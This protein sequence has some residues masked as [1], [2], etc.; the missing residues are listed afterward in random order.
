[1]NA[2]IET[3]VNARVV[4][5]D[6]ARLTNKDLLVEWV[7]ATGSQ[8]G[9]N[10]L[11]QA[12]TLVDGVIRES[13]CF[14][15]A[16]L[17]KPEVSKP[18][19]PVDEAVNMTP[20]ELQMIKMQEMMFKLQEERMA[21]ERKTM[22]ERIEREAA[23]R[24]AMEERIE[25]EAMKERMEDKLHAEKMAMEDKL[26]A[27]KLIALKASAKAAL[28]KELKQMDL[29]DAEKDRE[30]AKELKDMDLADA[31]KHRAFLAREN[32]KNRAFHMVSRY[33][34][35]L[36]PEVFGSP[37]KQ[38]ITSESLLRMIDYNLWD[39][40]GERPVEEVKK[41]YKSIESKSSVEPLVLGG[42][43]MDNTK[44]IAVD[45]ALKV[46]EHVNASIAP[47]SQDMLIKRLKEI[48]EIAVR[49]EN[50]H[51]PVEMEWMSKNQDPDCKSLTKYKYV[52]MTNRVES[53]PD[54]LR[55]RCDCC[56]GLIRLDDAGCARGHDY[57]RA[58]GGSWSKSNIRLICATCNNNMGDDCTI[59]EYKIKIFLENVV[60]VKQIISDQTQGEVDDAMT[61]G[62]T[63][64]GDASQSSSSS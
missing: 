50:R 26:H 20:F 8:A 51:M 31:E 56:S 21:A 25:R 6:G 46:V 28:A 41:V 38:Y 22:E 62:S 3:F 14:I 15:N 17:S 63:G 43:T 32:N 37:A 52:R 60:D 10:K 5:K 2:S 16:T 44:V 48:P 57:P 59:R 24:K 36:D 64:S 33:N 12:V 30:L 55:I 58:R 11:Y 40:T 54:G 27:E 45:E 47:S 53:G 19:Q 9:R 29:V 49:D 39:T 13:S 35:L 23:E 61:I 7:A 42:T 1:M 4:Y 34:K 18:Q